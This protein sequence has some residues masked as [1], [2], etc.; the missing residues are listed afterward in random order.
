MT[1]NMLGWLAMAAA[2]ACLAVLAVR[3]LLGTGPR[4]AELASRPDELAGARLVYMEKLFRIREP[5]SLVARIDRAYRAADGSIVLVELKTRWRN[6]AYLT[7]VIQLSAQKMALEAQTGQRVALHAFVTVQEPT[8]TAEKHSHRVELLEP[9][10][11]L[12]LHRRRQDVVARRVA[13]RYAD[14][15]SACKQCAYRTRCDRPRR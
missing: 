11:V 7:D 8:K 12:A 5:I 3:R 6:R 14:S 15:A 4:M 2:V 10:E 1:T 9:R 13:A